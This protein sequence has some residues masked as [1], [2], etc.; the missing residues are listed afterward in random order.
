MNILKRAMI[1]LTAA[2]SVAVVAAPAEAQSRYYRDHRGNDAG[3][4]I[5]AGV[6]GL[7]VGAALASNRRGYDDRGYYNRNYDGGY[8]GHHD[9]G[10]YDQGYYNRGY[11]RG[12]YQQPRYVYRHN[13]YSGHHNGYYGRQC[14]SQRYFDE[15]SGQ[16]VRV[17]R[18]R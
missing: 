10:H 13:G 11:D 9:Q 5:A 18:C 1:G 4:A 7:A 2:A 12:Y 3:V 14:I 8:Q 17:R 16:V 6:V 15:Y